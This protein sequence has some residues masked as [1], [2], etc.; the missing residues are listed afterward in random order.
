MFVGKGDVDKMNDC[1]D[2]YRYE[3]YKVYDLAQEVP[4]CQKPVK[5]YGFAENNQVPYA[6]YGTN[7][8]DYDFKN[9]YLQKETN[10]IRNYTY[11]E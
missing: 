6:V 8:A 10:Y 7:G 1:C 3:Q 9:L 5:L 4:S 2:C 11:G